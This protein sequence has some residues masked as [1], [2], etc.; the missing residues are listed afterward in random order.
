VRAGA[1]PGVPVDP[2]RTPYELDAERPRAVVVGVFAVALARRADAARGTAAFMIQVCRLAC[3]WR[4]RSRSGAAV[5]SF[6]NVCIYRLPCRSRWYR[7]RRPARPA[8]DARVVR[9]HSD[10][11]LPR[12]PWAMPDV[13]D[14]DWPAVSD[15]RGVDG[16]HVRGGL[17]V[18]W[19]SVLLCRGSSSGAR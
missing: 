16:D 7:R 17:V 13:S 14:G 8:T 12:A 18:L 1:F 15:R 6:L 3:S 2:T 19:P 10:R 9:K 4:W 5:G 11:Q